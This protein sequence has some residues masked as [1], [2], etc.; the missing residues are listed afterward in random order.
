MTLTTRYPFSAS[1]RLHAASLSERENQQIYG[2]CNNPFGHGHNYW[3]ELTVRGE[4]DPVTGMIVERKRL[5]RLMH[6]EI[7]PHVQHRDLN[8]ELKELNGLVPT[9]EN[10][11][12]VLAKLI[13]AGWPAHFPEQSV[14]FERIRIHETKN[15]RFEMEADEVRE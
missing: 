12:L 14:R 11:A 9:T 10:L 6:Q 1:H 3:I 2:K 8:A 15:N 4:A 7:L 5:D 13:D